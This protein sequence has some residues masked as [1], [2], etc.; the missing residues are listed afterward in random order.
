MKNLK[1]RV[2]LS[3]AEDIV[4]SLLFCVMGIV[5]F[6]CFAISRHL[7]KARRVHNV[8]KLS[9]ITAVL[10]HDQHSCSDI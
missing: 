1:I 5:T 9:K 4:G 3:D 6:Q 7:V 10:T 8:K 2:S